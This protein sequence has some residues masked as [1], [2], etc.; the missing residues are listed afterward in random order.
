[1]FLLDKTFFKK[2]LK[3]ANCESD[4]EVQIVLE[5]EKSKTSIEIRRKGRNDYLRAHQQKMI[6]AEEKAKLKE[7]DPVFISTVNHVEPEKRKPDRVAEELRKEREDRAKLEASRLAPW[8]W[9]GRPKLRSQSRCWPVVS[10]AW[11]S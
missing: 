4:D 6:E 9:A 5:V 10:G 1:L 7:S 2:K 8:S 11:G 3:M